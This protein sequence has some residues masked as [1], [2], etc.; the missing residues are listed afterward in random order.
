MAAYRR[1]NSVWTRNHESAM[2][3]RAM[4]TVASLAVPWALEA[5]SRIRATPAKLAI[6]AVRTRASE[7]TRPGSSL[8]AWAA[9]AAGPNLAM[10]LHT[11]MRYV[12]EAAAHPRAGA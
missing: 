8:R 1:V 11:Q 10:T 6:V 9:V 3:P 2:L 5:S 4:A 12:A 7:K